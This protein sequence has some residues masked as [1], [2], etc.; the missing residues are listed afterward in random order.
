ME[1]EGKQAHLKLSGVVKGV[2]AKLRQ[3]LRQSAGDYESVWQAHCQDKALLGE[4]ADAMRSLATEFWS[5]RPETRIDWCRSTCVEYFHGGGL[6]K[7][8]AKDARRN[9]FRHQQEENSEDSEPKDMTLDFS[10]MAA[11]SAAASSPTAELSDSSGS[12]S[13]TTLSSSEPDLM[14]GSP[15]ASLEDRRRKIYERYPAPLYSSI[16]VPFEGPIRLLDVGSCYNPFQQHSEFL[17]IGIDISPAV[18]SVHQ[19]DILSV[20]L[21][22]QPLQLA[23]DSLL[24]YFKTLPRVIPQLP[25]CSFHVVVYS[26]LL[27][28]F[29]ARYQRWL[30]CQR[31]HQLL[32]RN[33]LL[34]IITPDSHAVHKNAAQ[35]RAWKTAIESLGFR[36][37]RYVKQEH[38]HCMAFRKTEDEAPLTLIGGADLMSIPQDS[39]QEEEE[40]QDHTQYL[41]GSLP[42]NDC[43]FFRDA[44]SELPDL[45]D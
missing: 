28:Y 3:N 1:D 15:E 2:H 41:F 27:E 20:E 19:C 44:F 5:K 34:L 23:K 24:T 7:A 6:Q 45:V 43:D 12:Y 38:L 33:G 39:Q 40:E 37:W 14:F 31:A 17:A 13:Q 8:L 32:M 25:R 21:T 36:R 11:A 26:L 9:L 35:M 29:P 16:S 42:R 10:E 30:C 18:E 4:Y 22:Q